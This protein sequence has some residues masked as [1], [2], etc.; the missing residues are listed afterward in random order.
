MKSGKEFTQLNAADR[1]AIL[2]ILQATKPD[3]PDYCLHD[4]LARKSAGV[5]PCVSVWLR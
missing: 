1:E 2:S 4:W 5:L 3:L